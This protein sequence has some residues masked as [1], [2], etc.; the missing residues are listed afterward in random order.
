M[1]G[2]LD[3]AFLRNFFLKKVSENL[4]KRTFVVKLSNDFKE[5]HSNIPWNQIKGFRNFV[6]HDYFGVDAEEVWE[7]IRIH[8]PIFEDNIQSFVKEG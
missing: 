5:K 3:C 4:N 2:L 6:V 7:I 8:L 1:R